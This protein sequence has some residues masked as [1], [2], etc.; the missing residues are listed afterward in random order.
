[1]VPTGGQSGAARGA[2]ARERRGEDF[3]LRT[4]NAGGAAP[5]VYAEDGEGC[6]STKCRVAV[7]AFFAY[8]V[9]AM[10]LNATSDDPYAP[11]GGFARGAGLRR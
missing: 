9:F 5:V 8:L 10:V 4:L 2:D 7:G 11:R 3:D 1:V 6:K